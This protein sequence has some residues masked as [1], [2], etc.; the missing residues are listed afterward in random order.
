MNFV[1]RVGQGRHSEAE[2]QGA[3]SPSEGKTSTHALS[4]KL[5]QD[6]SG[7]RPTYAG[8]TTEARRTPNTPPRPSA[9]SGTS[10]DLGAA[11]ILPYTPPPKLGPPAK[12][13]HPSACRHTVTTAPSRKL[14]KMLYAHTLRATAKRHPSTLLP[15]GH[16]LGHQ[17]DADCALQCTYR[18]PTHYAQARKT[19]LHPT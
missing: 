12:T 16:P 4:A 13:D 11:Q 6:G 9:L 19:L 14:G 8:S 15:T 7:I 17:K 2:R 18:R 10:G 1:G 5:C 3:V